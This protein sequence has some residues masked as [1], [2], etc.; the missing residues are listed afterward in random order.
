MSH[1]DHP[2]LL[3]ID[4][5]FPQSFNCPP[6]GGNFCAILQHPCSLR[7]CKNIFDAITKKDK[8]TFRRKD[9]VHTVKIFSAL[10]AITPRSETS[11]PF[12][13]IKIRSFQKEDVDLLILDIVCLWMISYLKTFLFSTTICEY[14]QTSSTPCPP[15]ITRQERG[16]ILMKLWSDTKIKLFSFEQK[17]ASVHPLISSI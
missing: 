10:A 14:L 8:K 1:L 13:L 2:L 5:L 15:G 6:V 3:N 11:R 16:S 7:L 4:I 17:I 12:L 9:P